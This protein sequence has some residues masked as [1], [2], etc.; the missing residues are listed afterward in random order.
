MNGSTE[1][2]LPKG[3]VSATPIV[4]IEGISLCFSDDTNSGT[5]TTRSLVDTAFTAGIPTRGPESCPRVLSGETKHPLKTSEA[6]SLN[7]T[8]GDSAEKMIPR[9]IKTPK[10]TVFPVKA[11]D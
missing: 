1:T 2:I 7:R 3:S 11:K 9:T 4:D 8:D 5:R 10:C 6:H